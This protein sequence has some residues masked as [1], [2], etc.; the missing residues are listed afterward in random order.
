MQMGAV[1]AEAVQ[2]SEPEGAE[3]S[4]GRDVRRRERG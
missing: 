3:G 1:Q 4:L 2:H